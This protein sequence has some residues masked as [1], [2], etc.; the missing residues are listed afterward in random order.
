MR[1]SSVS[2]DRYEFRWTVATLAAL[3]CCAIALAAV[4]VFLAADRFDYRPT[5]S[6]LPQYDDELV[7][8][9]DALRSPAG[10][11]APPSNS[12]E[13]SPVS[14]AASSKAIEQSDPS[15][16]AIQCSEISWPYSSDNCVW[17]A[18]TPKRRRITLRLKS[19][20]CTGVLRH[21][22][23]RDCRPRPG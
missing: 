2:Q 20:W 5:A 12:L 19:P 14:N 16:S 21:Q 4:T 22:P 7:H 3:T 1:T 23:F 15:D 8:A 11:Q 13:G 9:F 18:D 6:A 17:A 10:K